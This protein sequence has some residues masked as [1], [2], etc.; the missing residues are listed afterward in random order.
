MNAWKAAQ[1]LYILLLTSCGP[2]AAPR[3]HPGSP[4]DWDDAL[5]PAMANFV[6]AMRSRG[7]FSYGRE[8]LPPRLIFRTMPPGVAAACDPRGPE[9]WIDP[10]YHGSAASINL[11]VAHELMHCVYD[12]A[13]HDDEEDHVFSEFVPYGYWWWGPERWALEWDRLAEMAREA[14]E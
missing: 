3:H 2:L 9:V 6:N 4:S 7:V 14:R 11:L 13:D 8:S 5:V 1:Y 10:Q 12:I